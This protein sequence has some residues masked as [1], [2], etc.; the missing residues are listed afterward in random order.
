MKCCSRGE[1]QAR[2]LMPVGG[3]AGSTELHR[4]AVE[5]FIESESERPGFPD[6]GHWEPA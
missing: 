1:G 4:G 2:G 3:Q 5:M 6:C